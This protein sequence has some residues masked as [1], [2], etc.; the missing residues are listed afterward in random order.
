MFGDTKKELQRLEEE[1][2]TQEEPKQTPEEENILFDDE[3]DIEGGRIPADVQVSY[4]NFA[5][6]YRA[7][8]NQH[9]D[10]D[11][12]RY[13]QQ[14]MEGEKKSNAPLVVLILVLLACILMVICWWAY[15]YMGIL[16]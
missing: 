11:M 7:Y 15:R 13:T 5:N 3:F 10:V 8:T 1:L 16:S 4:R 2:L 9:S 12:E 6:G 14:V